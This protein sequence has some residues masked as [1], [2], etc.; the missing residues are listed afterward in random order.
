MQ[1]RGI[2]VSQLYTLVRDTTNLTGVQAKILDHMQV[3]LQCASD[4]S[5]SQ[6]YLCARGKNED[7]SV[8]LTAVKPSYTHGST[9]FHA[10]D[11]FLVDDLA[12]VDNVFQ[13]GRKVVGRK[14]LDQ[15]REIAVTAYPIVDNAGRPFAVVCFAS[16][17]LSQQQ[18]LTD[19]ANLALQVPFA[20][21]DYYSIR[22]QDGVII[23]DAAGRIMY[24]NDMA[25]DLY[26]VLDKEAIEQRDIIGHTIVHF[27]LVDEVM[28]TGRPAFSDEVS[29]N[30][31]LSAWGLPI[32]SGGRVTRTVIVLTDVTAIR[33]KERQILVKDSVIKEIHHR[34]KNSLNTI[35][36]MLRMQ[37]RRSKD[38]D[39]KEALK[40][41]VSRILGISK[42]HDIL[43]NQ[44]GDQVDMDVLL[45]KICKLSVDSLALCAVD[46]VREKGKRPLIV[47]SEKAVPLA[48]A[49]NEL[50]HNAIDHGFHKMPRGTLVVGTEIDHGRLHVY[51]KNNGHPLPEDFSTRTFDLGLQI[52]RNLAEIELK[53]EFG[54]K[55]EDSMVVADIYCPLAL[56]EA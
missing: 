12:I 11:T 31:T 10:G 19:T 21:K 47:N 56:M 24:A 18:V 54:L 34:V 33:E 1:T 9:F 51:I 55:N 50:I 16:V 45:D 36:G 22:P 42:I 27:P 41:A 28:K 43:A 30:M 7:I 39:T 29:E 52:V 4:I 3:A 32:I 17:S 13:T 44:S 20:G 53:G 48:I 46:V 38:E 40:R 14:E 15:G 8:I 26:F 6:V 25:D 35:A 5:K 37:A 49:T 2:E 23:L